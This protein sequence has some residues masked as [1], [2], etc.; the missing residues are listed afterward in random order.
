MSADKIKSA[1][2]RI[3][4]ILTQKSSVGRGTARTRVHLRKGLTC[5]VEDGSWSFVVDMSEKHGG[6]GEGPDPGVYGRTAVG[7]CLA[8]AYRQWAAKLDVP[9]DDLT[10]EIEADYDI[11]GS[12][13]V[14]EDALPGYSE[15]RYIV[16]VESDAPEAE[17]RRLL[18]TADRHSPWLDDMRRPVPL[19]REVRITTAAK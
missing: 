9:I 18:D 5:D 6:R 4:S 13:G 8:I 12:Y 14:G 16:T 11:R 17:I 1:F 3:Q 7:A 15:M 19:K 10:V 2:E